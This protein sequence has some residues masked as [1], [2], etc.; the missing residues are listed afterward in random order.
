MICVHF[1]F[2]SASSEQS[3]SASFEVKGPSKF[4][5]CGILQGNTLVISADPPCAIRARASVHFPTGPSHCHSLPRF[6]RGLE[7]FSFRKVRKLHYDTSGITKEV[8][9]SAINQSISI[10]HLGGCD[11][12]HT[13]KC[14]QRIGHLLTQRI[15]H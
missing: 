9:E 4:D 6:A 14:V 11:E 5:C 3:K 1:V 2:E 8:T 7:F 13:P 12:F 10:S 15:F